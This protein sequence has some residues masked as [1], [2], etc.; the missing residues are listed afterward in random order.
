MA[1]SRRRTPVT[2]F[3]H[4]RS[5]RKDKQAWH[6]RFRRAVRAA[7]QREDDL[8]PHVREV[9]DPWGFGKDG[10]VYWGTPPEWSDFARRPWK[11][12]RK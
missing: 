8:L 1:R 7:L 2:G 11:L 4:C 6:R 12:A 10:K 5:E 3:T 9:S